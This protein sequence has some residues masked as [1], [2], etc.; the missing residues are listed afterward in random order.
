MVWAKTTKIGCGLIKYREDGDF[1][2]YLVC[3]Y[4]EAG[5]VEDEPLYEK[6]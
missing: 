3:N 2:T 6:K 4:G 1:V 5:N